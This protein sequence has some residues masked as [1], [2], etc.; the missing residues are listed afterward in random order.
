MSSNR[1][2][3]ASRKSRVKKVSQSSKTNPLHSKLAQRI[4]NESLNLKPGE[5]VTI[6]TW[7]G[8]LDFARQ[9]VREARKVGALPLTILE[10]DEAYLWSL[11]DS[12]KEYLGKMGKHEYS[13][14]S[15]T[16]AYVFIPGPYIGIYTPAIP[17]DLGSAGTAYNSSWYEAAEKAGIRG[18]RLTFGYVGDDL[19]KVLGKKRE[20][21]IA[22]QLKASLV[23]FE[24]IRKTGEPIMQC[25]SDDSG[26]K[27]ETDAGTLSFRLKGDLGI[28]DGVASVEDVASRNNISY[29]LPGMI[30]KEIDSDSANGAVSISPSV[31]RVG[32]VSGGVLEFQRGRL[33]SWKGK[34][35]E[36][37]KKLDE[38]L[39]DLPD[40]KRKLSMITLGLNAAIPYGYAQDRFVSGA[41]SLSGFGFTAVSA[42]PSLAVGPNTIIAKG[43][44]ALQPQATSKNA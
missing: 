44:I 20:D 9:L 10:D 27:I 37:Q 34:D 1:G 23:N 11:Q 36:S 17:K 32:L 35:R 14:L 31:T 42:K 5:S 15:S 16:D 21:I 19:A 25:L 8:G 13:L 41:V 40:E 22:R 12:P 29:I 24:E 30:W 43:K 2:S 4:V 28:E 38:L 3:R 26:A 39:S 7:N 6:E 18:V 33:A